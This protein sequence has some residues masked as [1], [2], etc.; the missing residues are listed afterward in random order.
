MK[1]LNITLD[2]YKV[3]GYNNEFPY[4]IKCIHLKEEIGIYTFY[5]SDKITWSNILFC[6]LKNMLI[7]I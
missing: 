5:R 3:V 4:F 2:D 7:I 1:K 6:S